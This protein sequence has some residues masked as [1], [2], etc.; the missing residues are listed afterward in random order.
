LDAERRVTTLHP[1]AGRLTDAL[2]DYSLALGMVIKRVPD[3][4]TQEEAADRV[5]TLQLAD[6]VLPEKLPKIDKV[7]A[8]APKETVKR[9]VDEDGFIRTVKKDVVTNIPPDVERTLKTNGWT[10]I[11]GTWKKKSEGVY[12]V[13][14]GKVETPKTNGA[15]QVIVQ[16]GG[17]GKVR[18]MVRDNQR[19]TRYTYSSSSYSSSGY[20][21][22][23]EG[24]VAKMYSAIG[25]YYFSSGGIYKPYFERDIATPLPKNKI[26]IQI[27]GGK[28]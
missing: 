18:V 27:N 22:L 26:L 3:S 1:Y 19:D 12:E 7:A 4:M 20:G 15:V 23:V 25:T 11:T 5:N 14:D 17:T 9:V 16:K 6:Y 24:A 2:T 28:L 8:A 10:A 21:F 13:T